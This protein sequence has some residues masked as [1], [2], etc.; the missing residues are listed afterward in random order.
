MKIYFGNV[1][2]DRLS[3]CKMFLIVLGAISNEK[4]HTKNWNNVCEVHFCFKENILRTTLDSRN[5]R[6]SRLISKIH[7]PQQYYVP[8]DRQTADIFIKPLVLDKLRQ[9][10]SALGLQHLDVR[11]LRGRRGEEEFDF[12]IVEEDE[13]GY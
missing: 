7:V 13:D 5:T 12:S 10:S 6:R 3:A 2:E 4:M 11:N 9:F 8:T 1:Y